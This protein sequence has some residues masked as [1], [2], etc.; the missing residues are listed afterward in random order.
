MS[1]VERRLSVQEKIEELERNKITLHPPVFDSKLNVSTGKKSPPDAETNTSETPK[2]TIRVIK[3][4][5]A[6]NV[7]LEN[8]LGGSNTDGT[9]NMENHAIIEVKFSKM[10][11]EDKVIEEAEKEIVQKEDVNE[12]E[13]SGDDI[14][15]DL[16]TEKQTDKKLEILEESKSEFQISKEE[17]PAKD[18]H[19]ENETDNKIETVQESKPKMDVVKDEGSAKNSEPLVPLTDAEI[20]KIVAKY[21]G[22][23]KDGKTLQKYLDFF[24]DMDRPHYGYFT[25]EMLMHKLYREGWRLSESDIAVSKI[26]FLSFLL[27][28]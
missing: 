28:L 12:G 17:Q 2:N 5:E 22:L 14:K 27:F 23:H 18:K 26:A 10:E 9:V 4:N 1:E 25:Y 16:D 3:M 6:E 19:E 21:A 15:K 24:F 8:N 11:S 7:T 20:D 13:K